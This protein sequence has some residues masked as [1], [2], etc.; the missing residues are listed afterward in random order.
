MKGH[1]M[2]NLQQKDHSC[3]IYTR[4]SSQDQL[5]GFSLESQEKICRE[6]AAKNNLTVLKLFREEGQSA[7]NTDRTELQEM[8][9]FIA[10]NKNKIQSLIIY[11]VDRLARN[12]TDYYQIKLFL[13]AYGLELR[14]ATEVLNNTPT[15]KFM[16]AMLA[17]VAE[18][19]NGIRTERTIGGMQEAL[20][21]GYWVFKSPM[22]Y[23]N[24]MLGKKKK[25]NNFVHPE[26]LLDVETAP[27]IRV[28]FEEYVKQVY[29]FLEL[30]KKVN[31][32]T[33]GKYQMSPQNIVKVLN[34]KIY[35][36][37]IEVLKWNISVKGKH[38]PIISKELFDKA[39]MVLNGGNPHK[40]NR[41]RDNPDFPL[42]GLVSGL[43]GHNITGGWTRGKLGLRYAYYGCGK[44]ECTQRKSIPKEKFETEFTEFLLDLV[45]KQKDLELL[46]ESVKMQFKQETGLLVQNN[47][48]VEKQIT[49]LKKQKENLLAMKL[50]DS[51][52]IS[53]NDFKAHNSKLEN[54][55]MALEQSLVATDT[56]SLD[57]SNAMDFAC[58]LIKNLPKL[59]QA[60]DVIDFKALRNI[61]FPENITYMFPDYQ[62]PVLTFIYS[63]KSD[64]RNENETLV[65]P[66]RIELRFVG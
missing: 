28:I 31:R 58:D 48:G 45:P 44:K 63:A 38:E 4:V 22:G 61:L 13:K 5:K 36:G 56:S 12:N 9:K 25:K 24:P 51:S 46:A 26:L 39:Q 49:E 1:N 41:N 55:L 32:L 52:I 11:K 62:T 57:V 27:V 20:R 16:E 43:C 50:K 23:K 17:G 33:N 65:A 2:K 66:R 18:F 60:F 59:W 42:R 35:Y 10:T 40:L 3:I 14:S 7:K 29:T 8:M 53:D 15:G 21:S 64:N 34:N 6:Y 47:K 19:D 37:W 54:Q 30:S